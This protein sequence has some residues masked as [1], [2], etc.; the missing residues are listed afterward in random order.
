L[1]QQNGFSAP[2]RCTLAWL[3]NGAT[4]W[5]TSKKECN[6]LDLIAAQ[7]FLLVDHN[8]WCRWFSINSPRVS[9]IPVTVLL[10]GLPKEEL[11]LNI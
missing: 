7:Y 10:E 5:C 11:K 3:V 1:T 2:N 8:D 9:G 4:Q 6:I